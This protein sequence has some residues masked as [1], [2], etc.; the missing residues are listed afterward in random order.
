MLT[1]ALECATKTVG[2]ALLKEEEV[3]AELY[4]SLGRHH[5]EVL[6]PAIDRL[7]LLAGLTPKDLDLL[8]CTVGPGSFTGLRIGV[9]TVKG[10]ALATGRPIVGVST[11]EVLA[12]NAIPS[13]HLICPM[14]DARKNQVYTGL[15]R[16]GP[17]TL[18]IAVRPEALT[19]VAQFLQK[20][21]QEEIIFLG[22]G[23]IRHEQLIRETGKNRTILSKYGRQRLMAYAVG[24]IGL[25][26]YRNGNIV[27]PLTFSPRYFRLSEAETNCAPLH[28]V[29]PENEGRVPV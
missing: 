6:L 22:D 19:D 29:A 5:A 10:L 20:L 8:A 27:N 1:L 3:Q 24:L 25:Q 7:L 4:L 18:P 23:A 14:L 2:I 11:L 15:Y 17:D 16:M 21:D 13:S 28:R 26:R 12:Q 9:S